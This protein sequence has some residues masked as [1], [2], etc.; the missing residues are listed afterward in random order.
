MK[1]TI[2]S[3][4]CI[5]TTC[6]VMAQTQPNTVKPNTLNNN[7]NTLKN[8]VSPTTTAPAQNGNMN[9]Q[10]N[11]NNQNL[12]NQQLN[13]NGLNPNGTMRENTNT[14][15][16]NSDFNNVENT[17]LNN[18]NR[19]STT[20]N[21]A[22]YSVTV[23]SSV[24]TSFQAAYPAAGTVTWQQSG[25]WYRVRHKDESGKIME[26]SYREDGKTFSRP[27]GPLKRTYVP[28]EVMDKAV[29]MYGVNVYAIAMTKGSEGQ[30]MYNVTVIENGESRTEWMNLDGSS[31]AN[32]Y[33]MEMQQAAEPTMNGN[34][35][36]N[37]EQ[38]AQADTTTPSNDPSQLGGG[39]PSGSELQ[40]DMNSPEIME[41]GTGSNEV[42]TS[43][44]MNRK[45]IINGTTSEETM[46]QMNEQKEEGEAEETQQTEVEP[47]I[48]LTPA[49]PVE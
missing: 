26:S 13:N 24:Q 43:E 19:L 8:Q 37:A 11:L 25:D 2:L 42:Q 30:E 32:P 27:A 21:S 10:Q 45:G 6:M 38:P 4:L 40:H 47:E 23:P 9:N 1:K 35:N 48:P 14:T 17:Q 22:A 33:R 41:P 3:F 12:N 49:E 39:L 29:E 44:G 28:D 46:Q 36:L 31:V 15:P 18:A 34:I 20:T 16:V 7:T 5:G